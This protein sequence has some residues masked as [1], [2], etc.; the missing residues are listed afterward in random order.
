[1]ASNQLISGITTGQLAILMLGP[2]IL[3]GAVS[4]IIN[5]LQS[6]TKIFELARE[7][8]YKARENLFKL[9][10]E[11]LRSVKESNKGL[12]E[13]FGKIFGIYVVQEDEGE[14]LKLLKIQLNLVKL[15]KELIADS[16]DEFEE[17]LRKNELFKG[18]N[19]EHVKFAKK[20]LSTDLE[21]ISDDKL[22]RIVMN[23]YKVL[24]LI[25]SFESTLLEK[26]RDDLFSKYIT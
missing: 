12:N 21:K 9:Y 20:V 14:R 2:A 11:K 25:D 6:R 4:I 15:C 17:E 10:Q 24:N 3:T 13:G 5:W 18:K 7:S 19:E 8:E 16:I 22:E 23:Y 1:M 26:K